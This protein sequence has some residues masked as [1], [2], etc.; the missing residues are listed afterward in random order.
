[1]LP[2]PEEDSVDKKLLDADSVVSKFKTTSR[3]SLS[4]SKVETTL[5]PVSGDL[6][7]KIVWGI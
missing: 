1:M 3:R 2:N 6:G 5:M 7:T 4:L